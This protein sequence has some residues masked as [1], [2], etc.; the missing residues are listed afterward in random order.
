LG[1]NRPDFFMCYIIV[2][3]YFEKRRNQGKLNEDF[4]KPLIESDIKGKLECSKNYFSAFDFE[5]D[6]FLIELKT[7]EVER[8]KYSTT[9][10]GYDKILKGLEHLK[11]NKRVIFYFGFKTDGLFKFELTQDNY[12]DFKVSTIGCRFRQIQNYEKQHLEI[13]VNQLTFVCPEC[14]L[15]GEYSK[16]VKH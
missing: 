2:M 4:Y 3:S 10:I 1:F 6:H 8:F 13:P 11:E 5:N 9:I 12:T 16:V 7:R 14:P 15:Q